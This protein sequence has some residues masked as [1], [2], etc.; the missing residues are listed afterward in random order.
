[1]KVELSKARTTQLK[2]KESN[3]VLL[4]L[5]CEEHM[6]PGPVVILSSID[7]SEKVDGCRSPLLWKELRT[8]Q[9]VFCLVARVSSF[10]LLE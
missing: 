1:M 2:L 6:K 4:K 9:M 7:S 3:L 8:V 5:V 10:S